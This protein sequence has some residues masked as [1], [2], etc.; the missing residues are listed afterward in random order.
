MANRLQIKYQTNSTGGTMPTDL[1]QGE[2]AIDTY[3]NRLYYE[4]V[5]GTGRTVPL[6]YLWG[7]TTDVQ[8]ELDK[9]VQ[10]TTGVQGTVR[11][12]GT[13]VMQDTDNEVNWTTRVPSVTTL[14]GGFSGSDNIVT[15]GALASGSLAAGFT[16]VGVAQGGTGRTSVG[17]NK[18][19]TGDGTDPL[20]AEA[21]LL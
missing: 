10:A 13:S 5:G 16:A 4:D 6:G 11:I 8:T 3:Y 9:L 20:V 15:T 14:Y 7:I 19:L 17:T 21:T 2:L 12:A 1:E 18:I